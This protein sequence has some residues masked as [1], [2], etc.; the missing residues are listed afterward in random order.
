ME[1][2]PPCELEI[3]DSVLSVAV[4][5]WAA[6]HPD[7]ICIVQDDGIKVTYRELD[8]RAS[9]VA[10]G[11]RARGIVAGDRI[12]TLVPNDVRAV[13]LM[14]GLNKLGAIEVP[15]NPG[16]VGASLRHVLHD[17]APTAA[18]VDSRHRAIIADAL[19]PGACHL[20]IDVTP[21]CG[22][23]VAGPD[24]LDAMIANTVAS[25]TT[26]AI[27]SDVASIMYT[28]GTTGLPKGA[29]VPHRS[30]VLIGGRAALA[31]QLT[32]ADTLITVLPL[33]HGGG[34]YMNVGACLLTGARCLLIRKFSASRFWSQVHQHQATVAHMVVSMAHFLMAQ[35]ET[36]GD[37][38]NTI[39]RALIVP[40]PPSLIDAFRRRFNTSIFEMYGSTEISIP[41]LNSPDG[42]APAGSCGRAAE[43]YRVRIADEYDR[44]V[45]AGEVGEICI[46]SDEPWAM[47]SGYWNQPEETL[48]VLR[49]FW[50]HTGDAGRMDADG[51]VYYVDRFK[52]MIRRRGENISPRTVEDVVNAIDGVVECGA[53]PVPSEY[54]EDEIALAVVT[55]R[56]LT[57]AAIGAACIDALPRFALPRYVRFVDQ[58]P[59]TETA[60]V[61]KFKLKQ[62]GLANAVELPQFT[63]QGMRR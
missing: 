17:A 60:K 33:F 58:L 30:T 39:G 5:R 29:V 26:S 49:N 13:Y 32:T 15:I 63:N 51:Y 1:T 35:A 50:F 3:L 62:Q 28:S 43:P 19:P 22:I 25:V 24:V 23:A 11:L 14:L 61:Q 20:I 44:V 54:G 38:D 37:P 41:I 57:A 48:K 7:R 21:E 56:E 55:D 18:V 53:Y 40:A 59:K 27:G 46:S 16:L 45:P 10:A 31:L 12:A 6:T 36:A 4:E 8:E 9:A 47:S 34:K 52:D 2:T 42:T